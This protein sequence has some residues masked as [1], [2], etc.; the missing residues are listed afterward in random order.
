ITEKGIYTMEARK[1]A[2]IMV[3]SG[4]AR[5]K[6]GPLMQKIGD[7][8]GVHIDQE[9][10]RRTVGRAIEEGGVAAKMQV[11]YELSKSEGVT[12]SADSTSNRGQ[13]IESA[14]LATRAP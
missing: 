12:I 8:F 1:L 3:D 10:S 11:V 6:V 5:G 9:I 7:I 14:H 13:N 4:C 2:R